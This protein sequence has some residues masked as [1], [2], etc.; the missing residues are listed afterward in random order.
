MALRNERRRC[1][2]QPLVVPP[3][4]LRTCSR[5]DFVQDEMQM[6]IRALFRLH[7]RDGRSRARNP[8]KSGMVVDGLK[9]LGFDRVSPYAWFLVQCDRNIAHQVLGEL[10]ILVGALS[11][12]LLIRALEK[13]VDLTRGVA[14]GYQDQLI[15]AHLSN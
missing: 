3:V 15:G 12:V 5:C 11:H 1:R 13:T 6:P 2:P 14:L 10:G 7:W 8:R 9:V 4:L